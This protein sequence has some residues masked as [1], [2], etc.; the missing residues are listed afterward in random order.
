MEYASEGELFD[1]I[2]AKTRLDEKEACRFFQQIIS[3]VE[4]IHKLGIVHRDLKPEN[5]LLDSEKNIKI[6]DFGLSNTYKEEELLQT[7]CGSPCYAAPEMISGYKYVGLRVDLWSCGVILYAMISGYLPFEDP[8][9][10]IL[11]KK[12]LSCDYETPNW[13]S[14]I[15]KDLISKIL[16]TDPDLRYSISDIRSHQWFNKIKSEFSSGIQIGYNQMPINKDILAKLAE[17]NYDLEYSQ[18]CIEANKHDII[19]TTYYLLMKKFKASEGEAQ[20]PSD[21]SNLRSSFIPEIPLLDLSMKSELFSKNMTNR[22]TDRFSV[23]AQSSNIRTV[24]KIHSHRSPKSSSITHRISP[25]A[26]LRPHKNSEKVAKIKP[27]A[28]AYTKPS[29]VNSN[30]RRK[31]YNF[32][33][34][35][36]S[37]DFSL[38]PLK[39]SPR[40]RGPKDFSMIFNKLKL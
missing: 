27:K 15:S 24:Y 4:Y 18:K 28:S 3:G 1:Y 13:I 11:Y 23:P 10:S 14:D 22:K 33:R 9:T 17:Y 35:N 8:N 40:R 2:V 5:L 12:I 20:L 38:N 7:A 25:G 37:T 39:I 6:I 21:K 31:I 36:Q 29:R 30:G 16:V 19:T 32:H 34:V 26:K